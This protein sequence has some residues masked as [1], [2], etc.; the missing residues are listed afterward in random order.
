M[1]R[2]FPRLSAAAWPVI[3]ALAIVYLVWGSTYLA[4]RI[5]VGGLPPF[6][7]AGMRYLLASLLMIAAGLAT[8]QVRPTWREVSSSSVVG[9]FLLLGGNG[10]VVWAEQYVSSGLAA[11]LVASVPLWILAQQAAWP[12]GSRPT[13]LGTAGVLL[14]FG[15]VVALMWPQISGGERHAL[16]A[17]GVV[18]IGAFL[19]AFGTLLGRRL[20]MPRSGVYSS[21]FQMLGAAVAFLAI[22]AGF[23]EPAHVNWSTV[24]LQAWGALA[25]LVVMGSCVAFS[26]FA[27]LVQNAKPD[28][29]STYAYVNPVVAV[30]LGALILQEPV[31]A[32]VLA[33][34]A[35]IVSSVV[36]VVRG[37]SR[38]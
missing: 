21:A 36:L 16:W 28:L 12:G 35:L 7:M 3:G 38:G 17:Q 8:R 19:W 25:Y 1:T 11:L 24:P 27:W 14:G 10:L 20:P 18:L 29:V 6:L 13:P 26:A 22:S 34:A 23:G 32:W 33:G 9:L 2:S 4:I 5:A 31:D 37:G 30:G 15:G